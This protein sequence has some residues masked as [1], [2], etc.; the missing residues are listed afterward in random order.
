[1]FSKKPQLAIRQN[2][3][4]KMRFSKSS[5]QKGIS[6]WEKDKVLHRPTMKW[7]EHT[8]KLEH[9]NNMVSADLLALRW[10]WWKFSRT[11]CILIAVISRH[12]PRVARMQVVKP[13]MVVALEAVPLRFY[14][15]PLQRSTTYHQTALFCQLP[16]L[17]IAFAKDCAQFNG[18]FGFSK[19]TRQI[20]LSSTIPLRSQTMIVQHGAPPLSGKVDMRFVKA[21]SWQSAQACQ[22]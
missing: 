15:K 3:G 2:N 17:G 19:M 6:L 13:K 14:S 1:M 18:C 20:C 8:H 5:R 7:D 16:G 21:R 10:I 9:A 4:G 12:C 11:W 22:G